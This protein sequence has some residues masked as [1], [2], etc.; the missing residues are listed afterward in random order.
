MADS[1]HGYDVHRQSAFCPSIQI[2]QQQ[3]GTGLSS[4]STPMPTAADAVHKAE[5]QD[6]FLDVA[7]LL[8]C[9]VDDPC[10]ERGE[11]ALVSTVCKVARHCA[12]RRRI[13]VGDGR[14]RGA[15]GG[16]DIESVPEQGRGE[17]V[18]CV[19]EVLEERVPEGK[20]LCG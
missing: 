18:E 4:P 19:V 12:P 1:E 17:R 6:L 3:H 11:V 16:E 13:G 8:L 10:R 14:D 2:H 7:L 15:G 20:E 5:P 9:E